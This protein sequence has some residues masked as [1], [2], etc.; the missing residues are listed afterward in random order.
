MQPEV[1]EAVTAIHAAPPRV[2]LEF[3][4]A[5]AQALAWL[6]GVGGSSRTVLEATDRYATSSLI[7]A[8]GF[9]PESFA[10]PRVAEAL[11]ARARARARY[12]APGEPVAGVGCTATVATDRTKRGEHRACV[13]LQGA[14]GT[15]LYT[16]V[17]TKGLRTRGEEE[18]VVSLLVLTAVARACGV[19]APVLPLA[20]G[21][22]V[23]ETFAP[24][25]A[26]RKLEA[27]EVGL[28][29]INPDG[30][31][32]KGDTLPNAA[33]LSGSFNPLHEGHRDLAEVASKTLGQPV[34]FELP[35][36]NADKA[37]ISLSEAE[38]RAAQFLGVATLVLTYAPL[39]SQKATLFPGSVF[40]VG[41]DTAARLVQPGFYG[42]EKE[43][44][45][46]LGELRAAGNRFLV[47]GRHYDGAFTTLRDLELSAAPRGLFEEIPPSSF[48]RDVSSTALRAEKTSD[49]TQPRGLPER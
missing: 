22:A 40:V 19:E 6:H 43:M 25:E 5:G 48:R 34:L 31:L 38:R 14:L 16:L 39:F 2:V 8:V 15:L 20:E 17:L 7:E 36:V 12:L 47:A 23:A 18:R 41:A 21:E 35:L 46:A 45:R 32:E 33:L 1:L 26:L 37:P 30:R 27:G 9:T 11:A 49:S 24:T 10:S 4:G 29:A 44:R 42:G 3:A 28:L 13:A